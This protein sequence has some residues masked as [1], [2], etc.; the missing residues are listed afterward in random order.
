MSLKHAVLALLQKEE[1]SGYDLSKRFKGGMSYFWSASHQQIYQQLKKM[2]S[3]DLIAVRV[4]S[5]DGK[6]D[7]KIYQITELGTQA[8]ID[9]IEEP[10]KMSRVNDA[11]LV[12]LYAG[13]VVDNSVLAAKIKEH[14]VHHQKLLTAFA[15]LEEEYAG[16]NK[17]QRKRVMLPYMTLRKGVLGE[18]AW[19]QWAEEALALLEQ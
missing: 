7:K 5:Q 18:Q 1:G 4:E 14:V 12:K 8:L 3:D 10:S 13:E 11:F 16:M 6:P 17:Q 19:L 9:W 15:L 2:L